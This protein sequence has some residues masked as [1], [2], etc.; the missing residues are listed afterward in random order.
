MFVIQKATLLL[1]LF[2]YYCNHPSRTIL[3]PATCEEYGVGEVS[4]C[5]DGFPT[6][7]HI[8]KVSGNTKLET[9]EKRQVVIPDINFSCNGTITRWIVGA[10]WEGKT[11]TYTELQIWRRISTTNQYMKVNGI[12]ITV[13]GENA[14]GVYELETSLA[15]QEGDVL[16]YFQPKHSKS[17]LHLYLEKSKRITTYHTQLGNDDLTPPATG[18]VF[19]TGADDDDDD[20]DHDHDHDDDEDDGGGGARDD[21]SYPLIAVRTGREL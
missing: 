15:F 18:A 1:S 2:V 11:N 3:A 5:T 4:D 6:L 12:N 10:K 16:G 8:D 19:S 13:S 21:D 9:K 20:D 7:F 14:S 17:Q